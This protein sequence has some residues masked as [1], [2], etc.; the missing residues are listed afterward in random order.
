VQLNLQD[1]F[2]AQL[3]KENQQ[4]I[5]Y[6]AKGVQLKGLIKGYDS[7]TIFLEDH[8]NRIHMIYKHAVTTVSPAHPMPLSFL[9]EAFK[10]TAPRAGAPAGAP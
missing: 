6:L 9:T 8:E 4:V 2:L 10:N 1:T 3:K 7:F 5:I